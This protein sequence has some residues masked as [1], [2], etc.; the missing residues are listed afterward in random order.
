MLTAFG[1]SK[2]HNGPAPGRAIL[3]FPEQDKICTNG[4]LQSDSTTTLIFTWENSLNTSNYELH[5]KNL[6][7]RDSTS[8][9]VNSNMAAVLLRRGQPYSWYV[10]SKSSETPVTTK[11]D[12]WKFYMEGPGA[13]TYAPYPAA[14]TA[15][16]FGAKV[17]AGTVD[18]TWT[19]N[20]PD[21]DISS[22]DVYFGTTLT[23]PLLQ[24]N[25][26]NM[27]LNGLAIVA[28]TTYYWKI[29]THDAKGNTSMSDQF[30]FFVQ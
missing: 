16:L 10:V 3:T 12:V 19:G 26:T 20:D 14:L 7:S 5:Y 15:P 8:I 23:P 27:Y 17:D 18:L 6:I 30:Q 11:S 29:V 2:D 1:C 21:N 22:Y 25:V 9:I 4:I 28:N 24:S 13:I